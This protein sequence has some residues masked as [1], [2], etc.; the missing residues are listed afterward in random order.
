L[1]TSLC[2]FAALREF[3][4]RVVFIR[5]YP[6]NLTRGWEAAGWQKGGSGITDRSPELGLLGMESVFRTAHGTKPHLV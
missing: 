6:T 3:L 5:C 4:W 2:A 1:F